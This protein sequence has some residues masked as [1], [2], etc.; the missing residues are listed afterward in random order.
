MKLPPKMEDLF[1]NDLRVARVTGAKVKTIITIHEAMIAEKMGSAFG[2]QTQKDIR[3]EL[4]RLAQQERA[5]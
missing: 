4:E 3:A 1:L 2:G 5:A